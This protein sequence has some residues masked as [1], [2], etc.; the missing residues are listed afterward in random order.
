[1]QAQTIN[2]VNTTSNPFKA[3]NYAAKIMKTRF[4]IAQSQT[5]VNGLINIGNPIKQKHNSQVRNM[6]FYILLL[7]S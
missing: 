1:V 5:V 6:R 7:L 4:K 2:T 3:S